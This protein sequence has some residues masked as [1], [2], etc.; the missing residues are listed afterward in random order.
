MASAFDPCKTLCP[1]CY[2]Q[3]SLTYLM[4]TRPFRKRERACAAEEHNYI[5]HTNQ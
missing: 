2:I 3:L 1:I 4:C 5:I